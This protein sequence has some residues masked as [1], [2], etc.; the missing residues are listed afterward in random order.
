MAATAVPE[1]SNILHRVLA[2]KPHHAVSSFGINIH[3]VNSHNIIDAAGGASVAV[4]GHTQPSVIEALTK[5][6]SDIS[7]VYSGAGYSSNSAEELASLVLSEKPGGLCKAIFVCSGSEAMECA[8]KLAR[9]YHC[10]RGDMKRI[11]YISRENSYHGNT[12]GALGVSGH[13]GRR[14]IYEDMLSKNVSFVEPCYI[15]RGKKEGEDDKDYLERLTA[16][17]EEEF[18]RVGVDKVAAFVAETVSGASL[19][20]AT[21]VPGYFKAVREIC[22]KYGALMI[23]DEVRFPRWKS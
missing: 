8:L 18:Q 14:A 22:N 20:C 6:M 11:H 2:D 9:Q 21:A 17:I 13:P 5:Q 19:G 15:Y 7:Y 16:G 10:E 23:L 12:L 3:L 1:Q 4:L